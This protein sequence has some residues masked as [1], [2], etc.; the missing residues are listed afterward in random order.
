[1]YSYPEHIKDKCM[2]P[3]QKPANATT[4]RNKLPSG[5]PQICER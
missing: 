3:T 2:Q 4:R 5:I 1:V